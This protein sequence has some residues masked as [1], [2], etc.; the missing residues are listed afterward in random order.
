MELQ[1]IWFIIPL[2]LLGGIVYSVIRGYIQGRMLTVIAVL[3]SLCNLFYYIAGFFLH[4]P[5]DI[6]PYLAVIPFLGFVFIVWL[7]LGCICAFRQWAI[8]PSVSICLIV[9]IFLILVWNIL[10][11]TSYFL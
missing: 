8:R 7:L 6:L 1:P 2:I 9:N 5:M 11:Y 10:V 4:S 3:T